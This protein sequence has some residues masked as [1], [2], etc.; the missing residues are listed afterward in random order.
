MNGMTNDQKKTLE[1]L[2]PN[3]PAGPNL[4]V[5]R[6]KLPEQLF[7]EIQV[8][9]NGKFLVA[10]QRGMGKTTEL[11]RLFHL[12]KDQRFLPLF[13][14]FGAQESITYPMLIDAMAQGLLREPGIKLN[15]S[16][17]SRYRDWFTEEE[18]VLKT[19][20]GTEGAASIGGQLYIVGAKKGVR[21][22]TTK[23][24]TKK[25]KILKGLQ[26]LVS[27][28][29][30]LILDAESVT[31]KRVVF[32]VDDV[33]KIQDVASI[34]RTFIHSPHIIY[35]I[36]ACSIFTVPITYATSSLTRISGLSYGG[37]Y[38]VP[39][40]EI[41]TEASEPKGPEIDF[42]IQVL[43]LRMPY[44]PLSDEILHKIVLYSGG[45][46]IDAMRMARNICKRIVLESGFR[47]N[48]NAVED[49]FQN[50]VDDYKF[51]FENSQVWQSLASICK[52]NDKKVI[53]TDSM[54]PDLLYKVI[55]IE[56]RGEK[57]LW[58]DLHPAVRR[59]YEQN[60]EVIDKLEQGTI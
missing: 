5:P 13:V 43:K 42:M 25:R 55:V 44:N 32:I 7:A 23:S 14:Q 60:R 56:Y 6:G 50:L 24:K 51:T 2:H 33:D 40:I 8:S 47:V 28:F 39:A 4:I 49:E 20:E 38:R 57:N 36:Q 48:V 53:M 59:L 11:L 54:L 30:E 52:A 22:A 58:F 37:I 19:E 29:N 21:H 1:M 46:L 26:D 45:V 3:F 31:S 27:L 9:Q 35:S 10:G 15:R 12:L 18:D 41:I 34:E 17:Q 16:L